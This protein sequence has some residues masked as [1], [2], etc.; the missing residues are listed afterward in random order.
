MREAILDF[1][2]QFEYQ[3]KVEN[4]KKLKKYSKFV[5]CGMGGSH[6]AA[7]LVPAW[8][9][10]YDVIVHRNYGLPAISETDLKKRLII[11]SSYS[12]NTEEVLSAYREAKK[13]KLN[14]AII[15]VGGQ[16]LKIAKKEK[17]P[18]VEIPDT[19]I[20]PRMALGFALIGLMKLMK[21]ENGIR[22][23]HK[24]A[25]SLDV[26]KI[27]NQ[28]KLLAKKLENT[29]PI[30]Y[31]SQKNEVIAYNWKIKFN[32]TGKIPSFYN[33]LPELNHNEMTGFDV[34]DTTRNLSDKFYFIFL[35]DKSDHKQIQKR[36][37]VTER[38]Y[39][40]RSLKTISLNLEGQL[41][42]KI[43]NSLILADWIAYYTAGMYGLQSEKV[44]M[45]EEFKK[46][47]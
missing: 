44:P 22:E 11:L 25:K 13:K 34:K 32:E 27:E 26:K 36:M 9:L 42:E 45:V 17:L 41:F 8:D 1:P 39:K 14:I 6:L 7:D 4:T 23:L 16:L 46:M 24:L 47:I 40:E 37:I 18:Y 43:F 35:L 21:M 33:L 10:S 12:G 2:K 38:L 15:T 29:V 5:V 31:A 30:I 28:G 3:P 20:Q 19:D